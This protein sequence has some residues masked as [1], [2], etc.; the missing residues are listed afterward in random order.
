VA[1]L[2]RQRSAR[3]TGN[4]PRSAEE[5]VPAQFGRWLGP[6]LERSAAT[7]HGVSDHVL[8]SDKPMGT[9]P[10]K[11]TR[12]ATSV[13]HSVTD[14]ALGFARVGQIPTLQAPKPRPSRTNAAGVSHCRLGHS[15][16]EPTP[17]TISRLRL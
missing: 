5:K 9:E 2:R 14:G 13:D 3:A 8:P 15:R 17:A 11:A 12:T 4:T 10:Q 16:A 7:T 6:S 1:S